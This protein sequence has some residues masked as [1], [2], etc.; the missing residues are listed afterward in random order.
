MHGMDAA[1]ATVPFSSNLTVNEAACL[2]V[3]VWM[4]GMRHMRDCLTHS[5]PTSRS[6]R[7]HVWM[8]EWMHGYGCATCDC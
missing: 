7:L 5:H 6:V 8:R 2:D 4:H 1:P 3:G